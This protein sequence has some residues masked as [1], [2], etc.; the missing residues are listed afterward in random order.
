MGFAV[1]WGVAWSLG[2]KLVAF[3]GRSIENFV[4]PARSG[5][6]F[7]QNLCDDATEGP[8]YLG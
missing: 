2:E 6:P 7:S 1:G 8:L 4:E 5:T 3:C